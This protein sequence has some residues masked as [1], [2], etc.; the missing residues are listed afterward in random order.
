MR[1]RPVSREE[2][3]RIAETIRAAEA[4]TSG[5]IYCVVA[6]ASDTYF[7]PAALVV[8]VSMLVASL[9]VAF[10]LEAWWISI[11]LPF[12]AATLLLAFA[13]ALGLLYALPSLCIRLVPRS[14]QFSRAHDNALKQFLARNVHI[15]AERTGVL[16]FVSL[17]ER[18]A[19]IVADS[20]INAKVP[21]QEWDGIVAGLIDHARGD[22]LAEGFVAAV[23]AVGD[24]LATHFPVKA[25]DANELD[26]HLVEI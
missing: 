6:H 5:E 18:Y 11:R 24:L 3:R 26:D 8:A 23:K 22:R 19:E 17:A 21:Q 4:K 14:W 10:V 20:G 1:T 25:G 12:F 7:F 13:A 2:H 16:V 15:T 9:C